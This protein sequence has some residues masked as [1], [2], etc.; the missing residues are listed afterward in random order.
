VRFLLDNN[1][2]AR[3]IGV[4]HKAGHEAWTAHEI[5][6]GDAQD[7]EIAIAAAERAAVCVTHDAEF[8]GKMK[9]RTFNSHV[10]LRC[11]EPDAVELLSER[12]DE[13]VTVLSWGKPVVIVVGK[14]EMNVFNER[15]E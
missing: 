9:K 11:P 8:T 12:L 15:W 6:L 2:D 5:G 1:V 4:L 10:R 14:T 13:V 7:D 3:L